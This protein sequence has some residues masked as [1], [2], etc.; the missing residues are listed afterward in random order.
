MT[1]Y[2]H[3]ICDGC[4]AAIAQDK[5]RRAREAAS[6]FAAANLNQ[7]PP[8]RKKIYNQQYYQRNLDARRSRARRDYHLKRAANEAALAEGAAAE[9][10]DAKA[11]RHKEREAHHIRRADAEAEA[12]ADA[13]AADAAADASDEHKGS[14]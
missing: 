4:K 11:A 10:D 3:L 12:A 13:E 7:V 14:D 6:R 1:V 2:D 5:R 9:G 8:E